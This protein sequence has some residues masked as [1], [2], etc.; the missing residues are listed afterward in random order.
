MEVPLGR[1]NNPP[2]GLRV[3][4]VRFHDK[5]LRDL[6]S[7]K[8]IPPSAEGLMPEGLCSVI[9]ENNLAYGDNFGPS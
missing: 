8:S 1:L 7:L 6:E 4:I 3:L 2:K 9:F 5:L